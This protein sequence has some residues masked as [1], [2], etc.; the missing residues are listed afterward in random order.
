MKPG[1]V[2]FACMMITGILLTTSITFSADLSVTIGNIK[3]DKGKIFV[4]LIDEIGFAS[5]DGPPVQRLELQPE[6]ATLVFKIE[7]LESG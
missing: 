4:H 2:F 3:S 1:T 6:N 5:D 7:S